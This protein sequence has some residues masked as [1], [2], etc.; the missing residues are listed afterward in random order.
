M[1]LVV[2]VRAHAGVMHPRLDKRQKN[3]SV[4]ENRNPQR[5]QAHKQTVLADESGFSERVCSR[6]HPLRCFNT[7][8]QQ[9]VC[10]R[11]AHRTN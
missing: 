2:S 11:S 5:K 6:Q 7:S 8:D 10:I 9:F 3:E 4:N 1:C